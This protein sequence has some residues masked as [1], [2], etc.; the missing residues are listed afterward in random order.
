MRRIEEPV[1]DATQAVV[2]NGVPLVLL[3]AAYAAVTVA[4]VPALWRH[5][6]GTH[7]LDWA[8]VLVFPAIAFAAGVFGV[9]TVVRAAL[10]RRPHLVR[11]RRDARRVPARPAD[12]GPLARAGVP[13]P[14]RQPLPRRRGARVV[15]RP[16]ARGGLRDL[17]RALRGPGCCS[18]SLGRSRLTS[19]SSFASASWASC[20]S[21]RSGRRRTACTPSCRA[22]PAAWW[23]ETT[24]DLRGRAVRDRPRVLRRGAGHRL[25][26]RGVAARQPAARDARRRAERRVGADDHRGAGRRRAGARGDRRAARVRRGGALAP[27][28]GCSRGGA[29]VRAA[30]LGRCARRGARPRAACGGD[31]ASPASRA[32]PRRG[33]ARRARGARRRTR[34]RRD[35][36]RRRR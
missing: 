16:R 32:R 22:R 8:V 35:R 34:A 4:V 10:A 19:P 24:V 5:R 23:A 26:R 2:L 11:V 20:W 9:L 30:A 17:R 33:R 18:T 15:A 14:R 21:T 1:T 36:D 12:P 7:P 13:R 29:R 28:G 3:A 27:A 31:R 25:R 6:G